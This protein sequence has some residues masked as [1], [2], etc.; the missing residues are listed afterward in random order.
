M[1]LPLPPPP[2]GLGICVVG[3]RGFWGCGSLQFAAGPGEQYF[4][5]RV[6]SQASQLAGEVALRLPT[7]LLAAPELAAAE[8]ITRAL[9]GPLVNNG[10]PVTLGAGGAC[11]LHVQCQLSKGGAAELAAPAA[12][13]LSEP[14]PMV[15]APAA[16]TATTP[17]PQ[18]VLPVAPA[19]TPVPSPPAAAA[20]QPPAAGSFDF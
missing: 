1:G 10:M 12:I 20:D 18:E 8:T 14:A 3:G 7:E 13:V 4:C 11:I 15:A 5:V 6:V 17:A 19:S 16:E 2:L 9:S